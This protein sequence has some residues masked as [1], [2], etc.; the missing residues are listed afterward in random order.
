MGHSESVVNYA[1]YVVQDLYQSVSGFIRSVQKQSGK[2][3]DTTYGELTFDG[4][5]QLLDYLKLD[6]TDVFID[7]GSGVGKLCVH[8]ALV[9]PALVFGVEVVRERFDLAQMVLQDP[10]LDRVRD[11]VRFIN[12]DA[13]K[14]KVDAATVIYM[15][16]TCF[17]GTLVDDIVAQAQRGTR[18][19]SAAPLSTLQQYMENVLTLEATWSKS[20][21]FY[22]YRKP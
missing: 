21:P 16:S 10:R 13:T 5:Q 17:P 8:T 9:T 18:I 7:V 6:A 11:R 22:V 20:V 19:V 14:V 15:C 1:R 3:V 2:T 4:A 12:A